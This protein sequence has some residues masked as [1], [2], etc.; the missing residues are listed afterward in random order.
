M[1]M[2]ELGLPRQAF[3]ALD[4]NIRLTYFYGEIAIC[5][6]SIALSCIGHTSSCHIDNVVLGIVF[7]GYGQPPTTIYEWTFAQQGDPTLA[8]SY[9]CPEIINKQ[10]SHL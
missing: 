6:N 1:E 8:C 5:I 7:T 10:H 4:Q 2:S 3:S 9:P